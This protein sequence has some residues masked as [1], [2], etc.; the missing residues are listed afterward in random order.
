MIDGRGVMLCIWLPLYM[1]HFRVLQEIILICILW[2]KNIG[3][4]MSIYLIKKSNCSIGMVAILIREK[5]MVK[6]Y[7]GE[8]ETLG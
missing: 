4:L 8:E 3:P 6:K 7:F 1:R 5:K 2:I